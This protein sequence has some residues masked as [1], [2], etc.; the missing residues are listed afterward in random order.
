MYVLACAMKWYTMYIICIE[1]NKHRMIIYKNIG[2]D[3]IW[4]K[5][6]ENKYFWKY[7]DN[8]GILFNSLNWLPSNINID[9]NLPT[10]GSDLLTH[11]E[12]TIIFRHAFNN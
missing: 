8:S 2:R 11:Q 1:I 4:K 7:T 6:K 12:N 3:N 5:R 10:K 9:V